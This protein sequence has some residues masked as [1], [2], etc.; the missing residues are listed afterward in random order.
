MK[1][2]KYVF[3][4]L[5]ALITIVLVTALFVRKEYVVERQVNI[6]KPRQ[7]VY[8]YIKHLRNQDNFSVWANLDPAMKKGYQGKDG[9]IGFVSFWE[10]EKGNV[11]QG[12]QEIKKLEEGKRIDTEIRFVKPLKSTS[13][14]FMEVSD[15]QGIYSKVKW[16]FTGKMTYPLN[17]MILIG[18][19]NTIGNDL[20]TGLNN[21]KVIMESKK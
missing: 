14:A 6:S 20:Q 11:G 9:E 10:S 7:E 4:L 5:L 8:D 3:L 12:A 19:E 2:L 17:V 16:S 21:L 18:V 1:I 15:Y 13:A